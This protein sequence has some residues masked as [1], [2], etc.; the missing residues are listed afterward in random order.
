M[1][2]PAIIKKIIVPGYVHAILIAKIT[3]KTNKT[4]E[5]VV[6][7]I[8][9]LLIFFPDIPILFMKIIV[10]GLVAKSLYM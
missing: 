5:N 9:L 1:K 6:N 8:F 7:L 10:R 2:A 4:F 3:K